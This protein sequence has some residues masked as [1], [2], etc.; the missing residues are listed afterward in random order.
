[1]NANTSFN[2]FMKLTMVLSI[3]L[4]MRQSGCAMFALTVQASATAC[5]RHCPRNI[6]QVAPQGAVLYMDGW[7]IGVTLCMCTAE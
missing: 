2:V 4:S 3:V 1:M 5:S 6:V 7:V